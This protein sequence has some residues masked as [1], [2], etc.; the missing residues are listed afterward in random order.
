MKERDGFGRPSEVDARSTDV[1]QSQNDDESSFGSTMLPDAEQ[2][3]SEELMKLSVEDRNKSQD[4]IHGVDCLAPEETPEKIRNSLRELDHHLNGDTIPVEKKKAYLKSQEL[5]ADTTY[6]NSQEF[7]LRFLRSTLFDVSEA[8]QRIN[9]YL[10]TISAI[11]GE[12]TLEREPRISDFS[13]TELQEF[14]MGRYQ[15]LPYR[16]RARPKGRRILAVFPDEKWEKMSTLLRTKI[17]IYLTYV[18]GEDVEAQKNGIV[19]IVWFD[20][21]WNDVKRKPL[22]SAERSGVLTYSVRTSSVHLCTPDTLMYRYRRAYMLM[23]LRQ[24][25]TRI[26]IHVGKSVELMYI[27]QSFGIPTDFIPISYTGTVK[28]KYIKKWVQ[29]RQRIENERFAHNWTAVDHQSTMIEC[30]HLDDIIFR[31]GTSLLSHPANSALR[32][33]IAAKSMLEDNR[34]KKHKAFLTEI[35]ADVKMNPNC[36]FLIYNEQGWWEQ[37]QPQNERSEI[38][39]KISRIV[40]DTR[41]LVEAMQTTRGTGPKRQKRHDGIKC[42]GLCGNLF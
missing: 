12:F 34:K 25:R 23:R 14:R 21:M 3:L 22:V 5:F 27:L 42:Y 36:Q 33:L 31:N 8:A 7:R 38:H 15:L 39:P 17:W 41:K 11:F 6:V 13:K 16:D 35:V 20:N 1:T 26:K 2:L 28:D 4:E 18:A 32:S 9:Q 19:I 10:T 40:R 29:L 30:P 37:V 24:D